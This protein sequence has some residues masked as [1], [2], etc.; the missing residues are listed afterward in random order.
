[1]LFLLCYIAFVHLFYYIFNPVPVQWINTRCTYRIVSLVMHPEE[2]L[3][4]IW[5]SFPHSLNY[6]QENLGLHH[7]YKY[8]RNITWRKWMET[9]TYILLLLNL[10]NQ[11]VFFV[12]VC[13]MF[14]AFL[15]SC[16]FYRQ[17]GRCF[18][19]IVRLT[20]SQQ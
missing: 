4:S 12:R 7:I 13:R 9:N 1:M 10:L 2:T 20:I 18:L 14:D 11:K 8:V 19:P 3:L 15:N 5:P 17:I 6:L 16:I